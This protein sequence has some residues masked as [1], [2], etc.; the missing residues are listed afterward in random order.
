MS[1]LELQIFAYAETT[2]WEEEV[3]IDLTEVD[4]RL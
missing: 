1:S 4:M 2:F 3:T